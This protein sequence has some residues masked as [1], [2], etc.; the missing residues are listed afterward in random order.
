MLYDG[1]ILNFSEDEEKKTNFGIQ[2]EKNISFY[3]KEK[4]E[5]L[6]KIDV[7]NYSLDLIEKIKQLEEKYKNFYEKSN[8][9]NLLLNKNNAQLSNDLKKTKSDLAEQLNKYYSNKIVIDSQNKYIEKMN[10][11]YLIKKYKLYNTLDKNKNYFNKKGKNL[12]LQLP[13]FEFNIFSNYNSPM[14]ETNSDYF[15]GIQTKYSSPKSTATKNY[16]QL[17]FKK[18]P[19]STSNSNCKL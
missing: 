18:R 5:K 16:K 2:K 10:E 15:S 7:I 9:E 11:G 8:K 4:M 14:N 12:Q 3:T 17:L 19:F 6:N 1:Q 13:F